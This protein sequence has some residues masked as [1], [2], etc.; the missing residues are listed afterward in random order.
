M[1][2]VSLQHLNK[3]LAK[4]QNPA[5]NFG[6]N[7]KSGKN[8]GEN[9]KCGKNFG[10]NPKSGKNFGENPKSSQ[11]KMFGEN[12][13]PLII[14]SHHKNT[15]MKQNLARK[16]KAQASSDKSDLVVPTPYEQYLL[17]IEKRKADEANVRKAEAEENVAAAAA[18]TL[19]VFEEMK[20][21]EIP[22]AIVD[23]DAAAENP[24]IPAEDLSEIPLGERLKKIPAGGR[25]KRERRETRDDEEI[26]GSSNKKKRKE[27]KTKRFGRNSIRPKICGAKFRR[28]AKFV[29]GGAGAAT[30]AKI[31]RLEKT[32]KTKGKIFR[33]R[34]RKN[35]TF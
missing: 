26:F 30:A 1:Q 19:K 3:I 23:G 12:R 32:T 16:R 10:E 24:E 4:M 29:R 14:V 31:G 21:N 27:K 6:K 28:G 15:A 13:K 2:N 33:R 11:P 17:A 5:K 35:S 8:F 9:P 7:A 25:K 18:T 34:N 22:A 20:R